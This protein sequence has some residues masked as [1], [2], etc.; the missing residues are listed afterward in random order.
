MQQKEDEM[1][2][3]DPVISFSGE[4]ERPPISKK[5]YEKP[6]FRFEKVFVTT[7]LSC[8]KVNSTDVDCHVNRKLS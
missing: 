1:N 4:T 7:A 3:K 8:G 6:G 2:T 5:P